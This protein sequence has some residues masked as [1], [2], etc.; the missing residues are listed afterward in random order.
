MQPRVLP[1]G[2]EKLA[3]DDGLQDAR[4]AVAAPATV[5]AMFGVIQTL[6]SLV[7]LL[8]GL[9]FWD[10]LVE[11]KPPDAMFGGPLG[12]YLIAALI[13]GLIVLEGARR[14]F[15]LSAYPWVLLAALVFIM[16]GAKPNTAWLSD[17]VELDQNGFV[18][19][20]AEAGAGSPYATSRPGI[21]AVGDVRAGS[22]KRVASSVGEGSVV[23]SKVWDHLKN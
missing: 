17:M 16:I 2:V 3:P 14:M 13:A 22:V 19:T 8:L 23:I 9:T 12:F 10:D 11:V 18:L 5:M 15:D 20:G 7:I 21:F 4:D 6:V 1:A